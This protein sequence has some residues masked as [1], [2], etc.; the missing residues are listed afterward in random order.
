MKK[1]LIGIIGMS[2]LLVAAAAF[3]RPGGMGMGRNAETS[4]EQQQFF[5]ATKDL[6]KEMHAKR[7]ELMELYRTNA[8]QAKIDALQAEIDTMRSKIQDTAK[9]M[10]ITSGPG[11]CADK[12]ADCF[13]GKGEGCNGNGPCGK[14][15]AGCGPR[16]GCAR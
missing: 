9:D 14:Q 2:L 1:V 10:N 6:R 15:M 5:D 8:D 3:A 13:S 4:P 16:S 7:F 11:A 12:G